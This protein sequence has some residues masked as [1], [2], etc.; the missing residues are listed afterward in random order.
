VSTR[1]CTSAIVRFAFL[2]AAVIF[3]ACGWTQ[4]ASPDARSPDYADGIDHDHMPGMDMLDDA[5]IGMLMID[6]LEYTHGDDGSGQRWEM[7][8]WYGND[9]DKLWLRSEGERSGGRTEDADLEVF[10]SHA[11]AAYWD[12]QLGMRHDFGMGPARD[13]AAFGVEGLAPY[14]FETQATFY[15]GPS[16]RTAARLRTDY[17]V[18]FTQ[19]LILQPEFE[20]NFYGRADPRREIGGGLSDARFGLRLRY[21]FRR[22]FAPYVGVSWTRRFG[23]SAGLARA[24]GAA[25]LDRQWVAGVRL[26]F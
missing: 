24:A 6:Q 12:T 7:Q 9:L 16:G 15:V 25:V 17:D 8:G 4:D 18:L 19:H 22:Q 10:W 26:W 23:D 3:P 14:F 13:W 20:V 21:E 2:A 1:A 11:V 5:A